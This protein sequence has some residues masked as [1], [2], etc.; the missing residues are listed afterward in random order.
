MSSTKRART[1]YG[2]TNTQV[3]PLISPNHASANQISAS[4][5][6]IVATQLPE[7][8]QTE[9]SALTLTGLSLEVFLLITDYLPTRDIVSLSQCAPYFRHALAFTPRFHMAKLG[10]SYDEKTQ[11]LDL[12]Q[13]FT[14]RQTSQTY[15][16]YLLRI[17]ATLTPHS[18]WVQTHIKTLALPLE[19]LYQW[20]LCKKLNTLLPL[21]RGVTHLRLS[22]FIPRTQHC[23]FMKKLAP[24]FRKK[25]LDNLAAFNVI[26][27]K[28]LTLNN[29]IAIVYLHE[30]ICQIINEKL[31][32]PALEE[33]VF[34]DEQEW[35]NAAYWLTLVND[36]D[37]LHLTTLDFSSSS[38]AD[39][40]L[41]SLPDTI[42]CL[43]INSTSP[44]QDDTKAIKR[45]EILNGNKFNFD[46]LKSLQE[47]LIVSPQYVPALKEIYIDQPPY[48]EQH[49]DMLRILAQLP[50]RDLSITF[51]GLHVHEPAVL[52][53]LMLKNTV[54]LPQDMTFHLHTAEDIRRFKQMAQQGAFREL[55]TLRYRINSLSTPA[56]ASVSFIKTL[57]G[58]LNTLPALQNFTL[59]YQK[60][61]S[62]N[63]PFLE[64]EDGTSLLALG[65]AEFTL[66]QILPQANLR[67]LVNY[68]IA[69]LQKIQ[70]DKVVLGT[71]ILELMKAIAPYRWLLWEKTLTHQQWVA[72][73][74][75]IHLKL[76]NALLEKAG[77]HASTLYSDGKQS[78]LATTFGQQISNHICGQLFGIQAESVREYQDEQLLL[79]SGFKQ[80]GAAKSDAQGFELSWRKQHE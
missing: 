70:A 18:R 75:H 48:P 25:L 30:S 57:A 42:T 38:G 56:P 3:T 22:H 53:S 43:R 1:E 35:V 45:L 32:N 77:I 29:S 36:T 33:V 41:N 13:K 76:G 19:A 71:L 6:P 73:L 27:V 4:P 58:L 2:T 63:R 59:Q 10:K 17:I 5:A 31:L 21:L 49:R 61:D 60:A 68:F 7:L 23:A 69:R 80:Q 12:I 64:S 24:S 26:P 46:A 66:Q 20:K 34:T 9:N 11:A 72:C 52:D 62:I 51:S 55:V 28:K 14:T 40:V 78:F 44:L 50:Q 65:T 16:R 15:Q 74:Q 79:L 47:K 54:Y 37:Y 8:T 67:S 39:I